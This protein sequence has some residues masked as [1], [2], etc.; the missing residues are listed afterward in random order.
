MIHT[1]ELESNINENQTKGRLGKLHKPNNDNDEIQQVPAAADVGTG[2]HD[3]TIGQDLCEGFNG[4][5]N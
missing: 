3:Q 4:E 1:A 2:V 5:N